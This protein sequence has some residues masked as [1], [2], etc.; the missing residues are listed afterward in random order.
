MR[1]STREQQESTASELF[2]DI[3]QLK[4]IALGAGVVT[5]Q[6]CG[7][8]VR[9]GGRVAAYAFRP[10]EAHMVRLGHVRCKGCE[11][12][13][14]GTL[15]V[16]ELLMRGRVGHCRDQATQSSWPVLVAPCVRAVSPMATDQ[17]LSVPTNADAQSPPAESNTSSIAPAYAGVTVGARRR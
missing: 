13:R 7:S 9:E 12:P 10:A 2:E 3:K 11:P 8:A 17:Y 5:C 1:K 6:G 4:L 14:V 16:R 15:G